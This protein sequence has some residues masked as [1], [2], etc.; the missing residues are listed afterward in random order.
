LA[1]AVDIKKVKIK[2]EKT[3][4]ILNV[5]KLIISKQQFRLTVS[6]L[7]RLT[8]AFNGALIAIS[9]KKDN[10]ATNAWLDT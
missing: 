8:A 5:Q 10:F 2:T 6:M 4:Q 3:C 7:A 9:S 1:E